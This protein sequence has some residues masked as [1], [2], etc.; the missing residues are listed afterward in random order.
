[1]LLVLFVAVVAMLGCEDQKK[2]SKAN[3]EAL[4]AHN[5]RL[6]QQLTNQQA[7]MDKLSVSM[8]EAT[9]TEPTP[10]PKK[11]PWAQLPPGTHIE[12]RGGQTVVR[13]E[14]SQVNFGSGK[15]GL[16][17]SGKQVLDRVAS[18][19]NTDFPRRRVI[20]E[21]H[22]DKDPIR[23]TK[24]LYNDNYDLGRKRAQTVADYLASRGIDRSR[25]RIESYGPD[26][27]IS[28]TKSKNRRVEV[29]VQA[30]SW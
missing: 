13:I 26:R 27:P 23:K 11:D 15:A 19:L 3:Y 14:G 20:V 2:Y 18:V 6:Q 21:G 30:E 29:V 28:T 12:N 9:P 1:M 17:P 25:I 5:K 22:T 8:T 10:A 7:E 4:E 24:H 16:S